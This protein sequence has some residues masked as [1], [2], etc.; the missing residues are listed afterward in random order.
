MQ[1][2]NATKDDISIEYKS[3]PNGWLQASIGC[4]EEEQ[5]AAQAF[6]SLVNHGDATSN[7]FTESD[8]VSL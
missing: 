5:Q 3:K 4:G 7:S 2:L 6:P 1:Q 8:R